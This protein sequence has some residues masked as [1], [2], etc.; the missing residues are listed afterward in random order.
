MVGDASRD[1]LRERLVV[2]ARPIA[3]RLRKRASRAQEFVRDIG[4]VSDVFI[5][6]L[7]DV[8]TDLTKDE[9]G[10]R[11]NVAFQTVIASRDRTVCLAPPAQGGA[12]QREAK[13]PRGRLRLAVADRGNGSVVL[14]WGE[15][16]DLVVELRHLK[17]PVGGIG[18]A[19]RSSMT[20]HE[21]RRPSEIS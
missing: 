3:I 8:A 7:K 14:L 20:M 1:I 5:D 2:F 19:A 11:V 21:G 18:P 6:S 12:R 16:G 13:T 17:Q 9:V 15:P 4:G 10:S